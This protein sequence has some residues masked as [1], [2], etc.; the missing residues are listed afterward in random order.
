MIKNV[1]HIMD[2]FGN[3]TS[4]FYKDLIL[5]ALFIKKKESCKEITFWIPKNHPI[6]KE[7]K[8]FLSYSF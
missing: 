4:E 3:E 8:K 7:I 2:F 5:T 6:Q 1:L